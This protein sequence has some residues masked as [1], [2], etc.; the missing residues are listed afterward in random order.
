M[1][2]AIVAAL[3]RE[4][5]EIEVASHLRSWSGDGDDVRTA[6]IRRIGTRQACRLAARYAD[7]VPPDL[8]LTYHPYHKA[9]DWIGPTVCDA[10]KIPYVVAEASVARKRATG[11]WADGHAQTVASLRRAAA[12]IAMNPT[13]VDGVREIVPDHRLHCL[14]PFLD[15]GEIPPRP[16]RCGALDGKTAFESCGRTT[17]LIAV[18]MMRFG[19]KLQSYRMLADTLSRIERLPWSLMVA[20]DGEARAEVQLAFAVLKGRVRFIG[21]V[22]PAVLYEHLHTADLLVWPAI[23]EAYG[24]ALLEAQACGVPVVAGDRPGV[25]SVVAAGC[26]GLLAPSGDAG[27][28]AAAVAE[29]IDNPG[30]RQSLA[31]AARAYVVRNHDMGDAGR[32]LSEILGA[33]LASGPPS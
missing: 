4:G 30:K 17:R 19:D 8:W 24:M 22:D 6:R 2:R 5:H 33:L 7:S 23:N 20:G 14:R 18:G 32:R 31:C 3:A 27:A 13:D 21:R 28:L 12:V 26:T 10:L 25:A 29:L 11:P 1:A 9:P 16:G 15:V